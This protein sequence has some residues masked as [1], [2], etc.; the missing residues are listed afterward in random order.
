MKKKTNRKGF[1]LAELLIVVAIIGV[2]VAISIP[3]FSS[4]LK[5]AKLAA[6]QANVRSAK[7]AASAAYMTDG[8]TGPVS[9]LYDG[10]RAIKLSS[11]YTSV[12]GKGYGKSDSYE[13]TGAI[14]GTPR[15]GY[16]EVTVNEADSQIQARW[17]SSA[18]AG[19]LAS[20]N[21]AISG[22]LT[23]GSL[24]AQV[25]DAGLD[26]SDITSFTAAANTEISKDNGSLNHMFAGYPNL[27]SI[28]LSNATLV[29]GKGDG[30]LFTDVP[31]TVSEITLPKCS[32]NYNITGRWY[33]ADG[34][35]FYPAYNG[36]DQSTTR[37]KPGEAEKHGGNKIYRNP[38]V[39]GKT[40][41][42]SKS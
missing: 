7:A 33:Y 8:E 17:I 32:D 31:E 37:I 13:N 27:K 5:K 35:S 24:A 34:T 38:P 15:D 2:L 36:A 9:Y 19:A 28:D 40:P 39:A 30:D 42:P 20:G 25:K 3:V 14:S 10:S 29:P 21:F 12:S 22:K 11:G 1:T 16:V 41:E 6:D 4:Q 26:S 23:A 18:G